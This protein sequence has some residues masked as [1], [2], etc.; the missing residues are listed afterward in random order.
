MRFTPAGPE[1]QVLCILIDYEGC[2]ANFITL[3]NQN[4][5]KQSQSLWVRDASRLAKIE[6]VTWSE[7]S[8]VTRRMFS[9]CKVRVICQNSTIFCQK[10]KYYCNE[11]SRSC[12]CKAAFT[13]PA[14]RGVSQSSQVTIQDCNCL[15]PR[16]SLHIITAISITVTEVIQAECHL[17]N[18]LCLNKKTSSSM[19]VSQL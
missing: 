18:H 6:P 2:I 13:Q 14:D 7:L 15:R 8:H 4:I 11:S 10:S 5:T 12:T 1:Y 16:F 3:D 17:I 9:G 19:P